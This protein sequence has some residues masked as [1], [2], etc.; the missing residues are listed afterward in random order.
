MGNL[1]F[2]GIISVLTQS[3]SGS[4]SGGTGNIVVE[5]T[6]VTN[7]IN[8]YRIEGTDINWVDLV[9]DTDYKVHET[10]SNFM[11]SLVV[12]DAKYWKLNNYVTIVVDFDFVSNA[13]VPSLT[14][15][16]DFELLEPNLVAESSK[17]MNYCRYS[18]QLLESETLDPSD[19]PMF[20][21]TKAGIIMKTGATTDTDQDGS[22]MIDGTGD[23]ANILSFRTDGIQ[24]SQTITFSGQ[25]S[26]NSN[27]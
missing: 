26:Y 23:K 13:N 22:I 11:S 6:N 8:Q 24:S 25:L 1:S 10:S 3:G 4:G 5:N 15:V 21:V 9:L 14:N 7:H 18:R 27:I 12:R 20:M 17:F 19:H 16:I 2:D